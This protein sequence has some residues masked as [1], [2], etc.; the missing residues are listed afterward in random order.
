V[1]PIAA[2]YLEL[3]AVIGK[4]WGGDAGT[5]GIPNLHDAPETEM[6]SMLGHFSYL[7]AIVSPVPAA[8]IDADA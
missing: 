1:L 7:V 8:V 3:Y 5:F 6:G 2:P 4:R